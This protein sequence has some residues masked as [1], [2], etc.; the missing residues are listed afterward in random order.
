[1][2]LQFL[3]LASLIEGKKRKKSRSTDIRK[4]TKSFT[5]F[6]LIIGVTLAVL[7][8]PLLL[9]FVFKILKDPA[10]PNV[11]KYYWSR[12]KENG[13]GYLGHGQRRDSNDREQRARNRNRDRDRRATSPSTIGTAADEKI[14]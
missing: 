7:V 8:L 14:Q 6:A 11:V 1:L 3:T 9:S 2:L 13:F 4:R 12:F 10:T 5:E